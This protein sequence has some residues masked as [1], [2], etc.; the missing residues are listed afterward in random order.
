MERRVL[1]AIFLAFLTL[2]L[3][4]ALVMPPKK[5]PADAPAADIAP[6]GNDTVSPSVPEK[7]PPK[8]VEA[9]AS[10]PLLGDTDERDTRL[11]NE[12]V[13]ATFTNRGAR[14]KSWRFKKHHDSAG[15]PFE[16]VAKD[17][18]ASH[19]LPFSLRVDDASMTRTLNEALYA[20]RGAPA[21]GT[22]ASATQLA[23]EY[24]D[25]SGLRVVKEFQLDPASYILSLRSAVPADRTALEDALAGGALSDIQVVI[26]YAA[27]TP[28]WPA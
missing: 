16:L 25:S 24:R 2:Y 18:A 4:Q 22:A 13:V 28:P 20:V 9:A 10:S 23:F 6:A 19:T 21:G 12:N 26:A 7:E 11:E 5:A 3:W 15:E 27:T 1:L 14:L 8:P 17:A